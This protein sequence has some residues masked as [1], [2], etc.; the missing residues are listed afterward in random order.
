MVIY[1]LITSVD[2]FWLQGNSKITQRE[3]IDFLVR[4]YRS[5]LPIVRRTDSIV[6]RMMVIDKMKEIIIRGKT[7][8]SIQ[9]EIHNGWFVGYVTKKEGVFFFA[10]NVE[11]KETLN[12]AIFPAARMKV[13]YQALRHLKIIDQIPVR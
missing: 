8:W 11:P 12:M 1:G 4:L 7:G 3:Q 5:E 10:T 13:T 6:K 2:R 9:N